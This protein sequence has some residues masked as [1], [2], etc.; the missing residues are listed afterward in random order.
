MVQAGGDGSMDW[1][2]SGSG[3]KWASVLH[4][5]FLVCFLPLWPFLFTE[6]AGFL[7]SIHHCWCF[8][9][10]CPWTASLKSLNS[11]FLCNLIAAMA[12]ITI[13]LLITPRLISANHFF[14]LSFRL[15]D[16]SLFMNQTPRTQQKW[17]NYPPYQYSG[18]PQ[19]VITKWDMCQSFHFSIPHCLR[20]FRL[21][22][23]LIQ[24][25]TE[26]S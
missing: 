17:V 11:L 23:I 20:Q 15:V 16:M 1:W 13:Y 8:S 6:L 25:T 10:F 4:H 24:M 7:A 2:E 18:L 3:E 26:V 22:A 9:G 19:I 12:S 5:P 21:T 14:S